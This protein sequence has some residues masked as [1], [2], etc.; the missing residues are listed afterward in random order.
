MSAR[1]LLAASAAI[2]SCAAHAQ[3]AG[4]LESAYAVEACRAGCFVV[5]EKAAT[6]FF[7][8]NPSNYR[9]CARG[10]F[11]AEVSVDGTLVRLASR[12]CADVNGKTISLVSGEV[13]AG[14]LPN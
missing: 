6:I 10:A 8:I 3:S 7:G 9:L 11:A 14:R 4:P 2:L 13:S 12:D 1:L 5:K